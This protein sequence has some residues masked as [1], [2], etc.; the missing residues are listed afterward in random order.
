MTF[1]DNAFT[2]WEGNQFHSFTMHWY[3]KKCSAVLVLLRFLTNFILCPLVR[4][5]L[6]IENKI[7]TTIGSYKDCSA[8]LELFDLDLWPWPFAKVIVNR[9]SYSVVHY[10]KY[11]ACQSNSIGDI[12]NSLVFGKIWPWSVTFCDLDLDHSHCY[13][14]HQTSLVVL[15]NNIKYEVCKSNSDW[16]IVNCLGFE[17]F[18]LDLWPWPSCKVNFSKSN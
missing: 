14:T 12:A 6:D 13:L 11:E 9:V 5:G 2:A 4:S 16:Y 1:I 3:V 10:S 7:L 17:K 8:E 18:D 15:Y